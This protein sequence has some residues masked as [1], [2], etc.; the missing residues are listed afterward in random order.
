MTESPR[1]ITD[2]DRV[3]TAVHGLIGGVAPGQWNAPTPC[4][5][6][7]VRTLVNHVVTGTVLFDTMLRRT[8]PP[9]RTVDHLG[10]DPAAAFSSAGVSFV[11]AL[12]G[13]GVLNETFTTFLGDQTGASI[14]WMRINE[15]LVHGWD[16][17]R[18]TGQSTDVLPEDLAAASLDGV[19]RRLDSVDRTQMALFAA[20]KSA[21]DAAPVIDRLAAYLGRDV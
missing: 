4:D 21:G 3:Q 2:L 18:A 13:P 5:D 11:D 14:A 10:D 15:Y 12:S 19:R 16:I 7:D 20:A 1:I 9:D 6:W 8:A 17:A